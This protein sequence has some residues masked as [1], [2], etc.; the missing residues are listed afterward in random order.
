MEQR[1]LYAE[2]SR[3]S[4]PEPPYS[5]RGGRGAQVV[6]PVSP[7][8]S[9]AVP[10]EE[11]HPDYEEIW[12]KTKYAGYWYNNTFIKAKPGDIPLYKLARQGLPFPI[13][14]PEEGGPE[15]SNTS[16]TSNATTDASAVPTLEMDVDTVDEDGDDVKSMAGTIEAGSEDDEDRKNRTLREDMLSPPVAVRMLPAANGHAKAL[17]PNGNGKH[18]SGSEVDEL[19]MDL[20]SVHDD[21]D[22]TPAKASAK[23]VRNAHIEVVVPRRSL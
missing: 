9:T 11:I 22:A 2:Q 6:R 20:D 18:D 21:S 1:Q 8:K 10:P 4:S 14:T 13:P 17:Q 16:T 19:S 23:P 15:A 12:S 5:R 3:E 7:E